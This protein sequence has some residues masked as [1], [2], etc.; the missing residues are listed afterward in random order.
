MASTDDDVL[1]GAVPE[2]DAEPTP[3]ELAGARR[4]AELV[5][6]TLAGRTPPAIAADDRAL[7]EVATVI[8]AAAGNAQLAPADQ[9][10]II[11]DA[12]RLAVGAPGSAGGSPVRAGIGPIARRWAPWLVSGAS[13]VACAAAIAVLWIRPSREVQAPPAA[14]LS[15]SAD[16]LIGPIAR[17]QAGDAGTRIDAIFADRLEGFRSRRLAHGGKP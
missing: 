10:A 8:R 4:F 5:D 17:A 15:R 13:A 11:E 7:L 12:L 9:S 3:A 14:W 6:K 1:T 2:P 16:S